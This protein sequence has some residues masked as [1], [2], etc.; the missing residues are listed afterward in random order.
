LRQDLVI[1]GIGLLIGGFILISLGVVFA[2]V[3][4]WPPWSPSLG[5]AVAA[6]VA[7]WIGT[8]VTII[9]IPVTIYGIVAEPKPLPKA[10][11]IKAE[12]QKIAEVEERDYTSR[13]MTDLKFGVVAIVAGFL[14]RLLFVN[15]IAK[16]STDAGTIISVGDL[17]LILFVII[18]IV[19]IGFGIV[20]YAIAKKRK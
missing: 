14:I 3:S 11:K 6:L 12:K 15:V 16:D 5:V 2:A 9:G 7:L 1:L 17:A 19:G 13:L 8:V 10:P 20:E 18:G 4:V